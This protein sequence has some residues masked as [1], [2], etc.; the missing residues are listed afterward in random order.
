MLAD[1]GVTVSACN[2]GTKLLAFGNFSAC[3][4]SYAH[5]NQQRNHPM[6]SRQLWPTN[7]TEARQCRQIVLS[8]GQRTCVGQWLVS[9][10]SIYQYV[11]KYCG[12]ED[13]TFGYEKLNKYICKALSNPSSVQPKALSNPSTSSIQSAKKYESFQ[14]R[15]TPEF[16]LTPKSPLTL[17]IS[18]THSRSV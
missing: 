16:I 17:I 10:S 5:S 1:A 11:M 13:F 2:T 12:S 18:H 8:M 3:Q 4:T 6:C 15:N 14:P 9:N 7:N